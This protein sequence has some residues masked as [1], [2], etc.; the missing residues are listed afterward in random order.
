M[1]TMHAPIFKGNGAQQDLTKT[2]YELTDLGA[3]L[4]IDAVGH[5]L[6]VATQAV[7]LALSADDVRP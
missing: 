1:N 5:Q 7:R 3:D 2:V 4:V 6:D